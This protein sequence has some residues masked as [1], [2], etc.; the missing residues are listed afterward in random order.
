[1]QTTVFSTHRLTLLT[2]ALIVATFLGAG[3]GGAVSHAAS[4]SGGASFS[5]QPTLYDPN[6]PATRSYYVLNL[7]P[8]QTKTLGFRIIN[9]GQAAGSVSLYPVDATT[10][11]S[12]G[13]VF[14]THS[15]PRRDVGAWISLSTPQAALNANSNQD[16][17]F[18]IS[19]PPDARPGQHFGGITAEGVEMQQTTS[20]NQHFVI[21]VHHL[22]VMAVQVNLPGPTV[23]QV[24]VDGMQAGGANSYQSLQLHLKNTGTTLV[25][26]KGDLQVSDASGNLLQNLPIAL[27]S[28]LPDTSISYP[29]FVQ[30]QALGP[31]TYQA[32]LHLVYGQSN[33][34]LDYNTS[35]T[36]TQQQ[37]SQTF[38]NAPLQNP[39]AASPSNLLGGLPLWAIGLLGLLA[40]SALLFW[41]QKIYQFAVVGP[42]RKRARSRQKSGQPSRQKRAARRRKADDADEE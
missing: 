27:D 4:A 8:G 7:A 16:A 40:L 25:S 34:V 17:T 29:V 32:K 31:G 24:S 33:R 23:E 9:S 6:Q 21:K 36:I 41:G 11:A 10:G 22:Y 12:S 19:V 42:R 14:R 15:D 28:F 13:M 37:V 35:F 18:Q 26:G 2:L 5:L 39:N 30:K 38:S 1:M 20:K 3:F